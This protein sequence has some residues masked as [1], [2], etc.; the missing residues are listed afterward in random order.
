[1]KSYTILAGIAAAALVIVL[2][3]VAL[4]RQSTPTKQEITPAPK[5]T[6]RVRPQDQS[7]PMAVENDMNQTV[8]TPDS[9]TSSVQVGQ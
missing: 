7:R 2:F 4:N 1:M 6:T 5:Q 8:S 9:V 3:V